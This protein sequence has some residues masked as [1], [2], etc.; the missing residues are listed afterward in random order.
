MARFRLAKKATAQKL[1][2]AVF[3][4]AAAYASGARD[5]KLERKI[6]RL[7]DRQKGDRIRFH[8]DGYAEGAY[9]G[10]RVIH[11]I[12]PDLSRKVTNGVPDL[13]ETANEAVGTL[14]LG[15]YSW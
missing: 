5:P 7:I 15:G 3:A 13:T 2:S 6:R 14:G 11:I 8:Y 4:A 1:G 12:V 9:S 10:E